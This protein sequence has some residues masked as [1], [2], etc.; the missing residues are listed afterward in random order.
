MS[1]EAG[2]TRTTDIDVTVRE[3][4]FVSSFAQNWENL[5]EILGI[6]RPIKK[7][8]GTKLTA[9]KAT[10]ELQSG[11][12]GEGEEIPY[13]QATVV[14]TDFGTISVEK[15]LKGVTLE[16]IDAYG[17]DNAIQKTDNEFLN[18]LQANVTSRFY[19]FMTTYG[20]LRRTESSFQMAVAM[21]KGAVVHKWK[22]MHKSSTSVVGF[23]ND[24]DAYAYL[25]AAGIST[26]TAFGMEY[27]EN[28]LG[29]NK[30]FLTSEIPQGT[31]VATPSENIVL[32]YVDPSDSAFARAGLV[33]RTDGETN[34]IGFH[35]E[36]YYRKAVSESYALM[37][38][39]L[40][41]EYLDGI[42][43]VTFGQ[44]GGA[45]L[46][47]LKVGTLTLSPTFDPDETTY[48]AATT[49]ATAKITAA[50]E[51]SDADIEIKNGTTVIANGGTASW[52]AGENTLTVKVTNDSVTKTY[53]VT[54]TKS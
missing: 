36:G 44:G 3:I 1:A 19:N 39:T 8:P 49:A 6:M 33:Y 37:G 13:S 52:S 21:A 41:A 35:T 42:A 10:V 4:D 24:L 16:A 17:Y 2:V 14:E 26:Q 9:K 20:A 29:F 53:T 27:L 38:M 18:E 7:A 28:F 23:V 50:A 43:V 32:Y 31:V 15:Y 25:G 34:L 51:Y 46:S 45:N 48:T 11:A 54:V 47:S 12:V 30:L 40:F 22:Q 5:R